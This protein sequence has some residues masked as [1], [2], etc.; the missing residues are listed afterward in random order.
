[1]KRILVIEDDTLQINT[2]FYSYTDED[3]DEITRW[4]ERPT[5]SYHLLGKLRDQNLSKEEFIEQYNALN[6]L[7][8]PT[9]SQEILRELI[10]V[11]DK[12]SSIVHLNPPQKKPRLLVH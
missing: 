12:A 1:M 8:P 9:V 6:E 2:S 11:A 4:I 7:K 3:G 10:P 5:R